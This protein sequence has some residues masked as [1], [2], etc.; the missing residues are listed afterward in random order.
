MVAVRGREQVLRKTSQAR[1][2]PAILST[3][4][5]SLARWMIRRNFLSFSELDNAASEVFLDDMADETALAD[6]RPSRHSRK[7][8]QTMRTMRPQTL[9]ARA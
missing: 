9:M 3:G 4:I 6:L 5:G 2:A 7:R 1:Q 8:F